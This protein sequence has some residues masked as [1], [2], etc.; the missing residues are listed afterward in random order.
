M[1]RNLDRRVEAMLPILNPTVHQQVL[2][3]MPSRGPTGS[4]WS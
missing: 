1:S 4:G 2:D 3:S